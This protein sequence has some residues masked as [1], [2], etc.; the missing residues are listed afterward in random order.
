MKK[1]LAL[2]AGLMAV[3]GASYAAAPGQANVPAIVMFLVFIVGTMGITYWAA[4]QTK[5]TSDF[6]TAGGGITGFQN[7]LAIAGDYLS[8]ASFLGIAGMVYVSGFDG[9]VYAIGFLFGWPVVMFLIAERLRNLGKY[10]F[11]DVTSFRM[12]QTPIRLLAASASLII[13]ALYLIAQMV[14]AGKLIVLLFGI[15]YK[16]AVVIVGSLMMI[17]VTFG[18][19]TATTWVQIIKA[20]LMLFGATL[21]SFLVLA[22]FSFNPDRMLAEAVAAHP[23]G[24]SIMAPGQSLISNP[25][26]ALSLGLGLAL[27][28]AGLPHILMR[29]FTV[30]NAKEAR[31]SVIYASSFIGYFYLLTFIIGFGA[32]ALLVRH[33]EYYATNPDGSFDMLTS[34]I[35]GTNMVAVH[36][37]NA[38]GGSLLLGFLAAVTFAT[39]VA[40][41]AG[42]ALAGA[43]AISH[44]LYANVFARGRATEKMQMR[45]SKIS[46]ISLGVIAI[47][48]G[49]IFEN[50]N[51]AFMV[52]LAFAIAASANFPVLVLSISWRGCT[53]RGATLGGFIGLVVATLWVV[54]SKTVWVDV[55]GFATPITP[56]PN[57]GIV[58]IPLAFIAIWFFSVTDK[59]ARAVRE[60]A[61]FDALTVRSQTGI[62]ASSASAH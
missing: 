15:N 36:L 62:G 40:V 17:Y 24:I 53:T 49:I 50:Q 44:D 7:G 35:G 56:F 20:V 5:T 6:Y 58:S 33:P 55:F 22:A 10:N 2:F 43:A 27:G 26:N 21:M 19:M 32:I 47:L 45:I 1:T 8:A 37:A 31:K 46:T 13:I 16:L 59:S 12:E 30:S 38:V 14:G 18:G 51:V 4:R 54:L 48:L 34:L 41:V 9:M 39:I 28:T 61:A 57:P 11:A 3:S 42:L 25:W 60:R 23:N 29:F 52:G